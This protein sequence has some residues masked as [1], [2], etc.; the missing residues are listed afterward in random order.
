H[1]THRR[2]LECAHTPIAWDDEQVDKTDSESL[3]DEEDCL[4][5]LALEKLKLG[6]EEDDDEKLK[7]KI[8]D[9]E[10]K[11]IT[12]EIED[13]NKN[14]NNENCD[15][16]EEKQ[17]ALQEKNKKISDDDVL[18]QV[19]SPEQQT[20]TKL[21]KAKLQKY[22]SK[23]NRDLPEQNKPI[24]SKEA[25]E[26]L[27]K[28]K[29]VDD[30]TFVCKSKPRRPDREVRPKSSPTRPVSAPA[31]YVSYDNNRPPFCAYGGG[32]SVTV[33]GQQRTFN[34]RASKQVY[35]AAVE[36]HY[37]QKEAER[38][39][40]SAERKAFLREK[41]KKKALAEKMARETASWQSEYCRNFPSYD[42]AEYERNCTSR[43][44]KRRTH[45]MVLW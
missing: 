41:R 42:S 11:Q 33:T 7:I 24:K 15:K 31:T 27:L 26:D 12:C 37:K 38:K 19:R 18:I 17:E 35:T 16:K 29:K 28:P 20:L 34:V 10:Q 1:R 21:A 4:G 9:R 45:F 30:K 5:K 3:N 2:E 36:A 14:N 13:K 22:A 25:N 43:N 39:R 6:T 23:E 44:A 8:G 40:R 32:N